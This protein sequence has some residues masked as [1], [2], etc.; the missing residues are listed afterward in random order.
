MKDPKSS[1]IVRELAQRQRGKSAAKWSAWFIF[2]AGAI[3]LLVGANI[4]LEVFK[5][6]QALDIHDPVFGM[7]FRYLLLVVGIAEMAV[8]WVCLFT[9]KKTLSLGLVAWLAMEFAGYRI[10]L[11]TMGWHHSLG[12]LVDP[13]N[14]SIR[15]TDIITELTSVCLLMGSV[16]LLWFGR[17]A[18]E[19]DGAAPS[20]P[21]PRSQ[22]RASA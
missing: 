4:V 15:A 10:G 11:W 13:L 2:C 8:A 19:S 9:D 7:S 3:L 17:K 16:T 5:K 20:V 12:F 21:T 14:L 18:V 1:A 22:Y 6:S